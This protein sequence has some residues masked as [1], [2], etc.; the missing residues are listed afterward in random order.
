[1]L[2]IGCTENAEFQLHPNGWAEPGSDLFHT[3]KIRVSGVQ[4]CLDC[5][6]DPDLSSLTG[7]TSGVSC[8]GCH[9]DNNTG[10]PSSDWV[11]PLDTLAFHGITANRDRWRKLTDQDTTVSLENRCSVCHDYY[12][13]NI[14]TIPRINV[15][16]VFCTDCHTRNTSETDKIIVTCDVCH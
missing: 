5:H 16:G 11:N 15:V 9:D 6:G 8:A 13:A 7:G 4:T 10:H 3:S 2:I 14:N 12:H 1:M